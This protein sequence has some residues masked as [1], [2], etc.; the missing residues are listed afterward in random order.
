[1]DNDCSL[2]NEILNPDSLAS[3]MSRWDGKRRVQRNVN[4]GEGFV[5]E[6]EMKEYDIYEYY[7]RSISPNKL[8]K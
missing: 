2:E 6:E 7:L 1:M 3:R 5:S 8:N 4:K